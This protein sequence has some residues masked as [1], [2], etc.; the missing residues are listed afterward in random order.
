[1]KKLIVILLALMLVISTAACGSKKDISAEKT[2]N[3][4]ESDTSQNDTIDDKSP[5][6]MAVVTSF[7]SYGGNIHLSYDENGNC[8][9]IVR[10]DDT[11]SIK[12]I[13]YDEKYNIT[14]I[15]AAVSWREGDEPVDVTLDFEYDENNDLVKVYGT[16]QNIGQKMEF[17]CRSY[18]AD[19][20]VYKYEF[21]A[22]S[23]R[24]FTLKYDNKGN[25]IEETHFDEV[26]GNTLKCTFFYEY[27][28]EGK[29]TK[30]SYPVAEEYEKLNMHYYQEYIHNYD[31]NGRLIS[32][33]SDDDLYTFEYTESGKLK[34]SNYYSDYPYYAYEYN[35]HDNL[36]A[37]RCEG[38]ADPIYSYEYAYYELPY[39]Q[40][41]KV[42]AFNK[43]IGINF[44]NY[45]SFD[46]YGYKDDIFNLTSLFYMM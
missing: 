37:V 44:P 4:A 42:S 7:D 16:Q 27:D 36:I 1:M 2:D 39:E 21:S 30:V 11:Y 13:T 20:N 25:L 23:E 46:L 32:I 41:M 10:D 40:A 34:L 8:T 45:P 26:E 5:K 12:D 28:N 22:Y 3:V 18:D 29:L 43:L 17:F 15:V 38:E 24:D 19:N 35:E 9:Q 33:L 14:S 31:E 6:T